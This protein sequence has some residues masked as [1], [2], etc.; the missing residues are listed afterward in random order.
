V[1][2]EG[3]VKHLSGQSFRSLYEE[4]GFDEVWQERRRGFLPFLMTVGRAVKAAGAGQGR[5]AA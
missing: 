5:K 3:A 1:M 2:M 4:I